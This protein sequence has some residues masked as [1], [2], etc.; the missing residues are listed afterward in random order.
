MELKVRRRP[1]ALDKTRS[2]KPLLN[3]VSTRS[4][5]VVE[6]RHRRWLPGSARGDL[7]APGD[8]A[9]I[10]YEL[11]VMLG[12]RRPGCLVQCQ[13]L[14]TGRRV[15][16]GSGMGRWPVGL[17]AGQARARGVT[18][19]ECQKHPTP[20]RDTGR[21]DVAGSGL[22]RLSAGCFAPKAVLLKGLAAPRGAPA[23]PRA[24]VRG[25]PRRWPADCWTT[26]SRLGHRPGVLAD[27]VVRALWALIRAVARAKLPTIRGDLICTAGSI[28]TTEE[29]QPRRPAAQVG[30]ALTRDEAVARP[31]RAI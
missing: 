8:V 5:L 4:T 20:R 18:L 31:G 16:H 15:R 17:G 21:G 24:G 14:S 2:A 19:V 26:G 10:R 28:V 12:C 30:P 29:R 22:R 6:A 11:G 3:H 27:A 9:H 13:L 25:V 23:R 7:A 1:G